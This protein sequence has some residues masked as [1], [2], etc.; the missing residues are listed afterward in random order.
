MIKDLQKFDRINIEIVNTCNLKCSFCPTPERPAHHMTPADFARLAESLAPMTREVVLHLLGEPL[1]H[2]EFGRILDAA[3]A[4]SLP[5]NVVTNGLLLAG[6]RVEALLRPVVRQVSVSLQSFGN[7]YPDRD[8]GPYLAKIKRFT[9]RAFMERPD[10]YVNLRF[11]D[12]AGAAATETNHNQELR[13]TLAEMYQF[14]WSDVQVDVRRRKSHRIQG[15]LYLHF[16]SRF[17]WPDIK[18]EKKQT[19][20]HCHGLTGHF[21]IH[22][23]GTVVP[24]CLDHNADIPLGNALMQ[25][26]TEILSSPR[27]RTMREG[28]AKGVLTEDLCKTCGY[29]ERFKRQGQTKVEVN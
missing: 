26:I 13:R 16:D 12:L 6:D 17:T 11:W 14:S 19:T 20:G 22:A 29:I 23:D 18:A 5:V 4:V 10:L 24:C 25:P 9:D 7:N 27:A 2:P 15:R 8:V 3:A 1:S 28:F 21:G